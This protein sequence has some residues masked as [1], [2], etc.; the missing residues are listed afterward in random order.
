M[1]I[2]DNYRRI[3]DAVAEAALRSGRRPED[4][5]VIA[6]T[7]FVPVE[8]IAEAVAAGARSI[9]EN[10]VQEFREKLEFFDA[11]GVRKSIIGQLQ[12]NKVKYVLGKCD[13][14]QSVDRLSLAEEISRR[15][16]AMGIVQDVLV[17]VNI[18][19]EEQKGGIAPESA[20]ALITVISGLPGIAVKGL[21]CIPP[22]LGAVELRKCFASMRELFE[23][24]ASGTANGARMQHLSMGMS[25]DYIAAIEEGANMVRI[26][27]ALFGERTR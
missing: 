12:S 14:I 4:V 11:C 10:R 26:G 18:G 22:V 6:V 13:L 9:G 7:K 3:T 19:G 23:R 16:S 2:A 17:E 8:R 1:S 25:G 27:S 5:E 15:A 20:E 21:M 24:L